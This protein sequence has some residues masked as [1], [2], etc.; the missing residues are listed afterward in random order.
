[1]ATTLPPLQNITALNVHP[2]TAVMPVSLDTQMSPTPNAFMANVAGNVQFLDAWGNLA[3]IA[4][5]A[6]TI[7]PIRTQ[8][9]L[10]AGTTATGVQVLYQG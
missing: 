10:S 5:L 8:V 1:M 9:I 7:Y 6:G 3:T 4:V 2:Y